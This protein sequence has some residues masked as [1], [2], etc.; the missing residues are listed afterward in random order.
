M[1][2][3]VSDLRQSQFQ[4]HLT[5]KD[6]AITATQV[7]HKVE[8]PP[9]DA[10]WG[11]IETGDVD[12]QPWRSPFT[13]LTPDLV[14]ATKGGLASLLLSHAVGWCSPKRNRDGFRSAVVEDGVPYWVGNYLSFGLAAGTSATKARHAIDKLVRMGFLHRRGR[15][16]LYLTPT[17]VGWRL[18]YPEA[19]ETCV[20]PPRVYGYG[21][22][23]DFRGIPDPAVRPSMRS[24]T[25]PTGS[26]RSN[27]KVVTVPTT[28]IMICRE[29]FNAALVLSNLQFWYIDNQWRSKLRT[30]GGKHGWFWK[31]WKQHSS[32][33]GLTAPQLRSAVSAL[34]DLGFVETGTFKALTGTRLKAH[35]RLNTDAMRQALHELVFEA[36]NW[37][38]KDEYDA[39]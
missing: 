1:S 12:K 13:T 25:T 27:R 2:T 18:R 4:R 35:F 31:T 15:D 36:G 34:G 33:T 7:G 28:A 26:L 16:P 9:D 5:T 8:E 20:L 11:E 21:N 10:F 29:N 3:P 38:R 24:Q 19:T 22:S 37:Y 39:P 14:L 6:S 32:E 30:L 17:D 23:A